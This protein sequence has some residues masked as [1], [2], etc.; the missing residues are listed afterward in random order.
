[1]SFPLEE[2]EV[3]ISM[4]E[5]QVTIR[6][7]CSPPLA[8]L[9]Y[10]QTSKD[11]WTRVASP[12]CTYPLVGVIRDGKAFGSC[13]ACAKVYAFEGEVFEL[14]EYGPPRRILRTLGFTDPIE[15]IILE[16][17]FEALYL[18]IEDAFNGGDPERVNALFKARSGPLLRVP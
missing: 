9:N 14:A 12:C 10:R 15:L 18:E 5:R 16:T 13:Q 1:M 3:K 4:G 11:F 6:T 2:I 17:A 8:V 7:N